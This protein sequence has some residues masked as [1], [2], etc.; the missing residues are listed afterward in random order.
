MTRTL[1]VASR[2][3][4]GILAAPLMATLFQYGQFTTHDVLMSRSALIA[5]AVGLTGII[6]VKI[7]APGYYAR[8]N[9]KTPVKIAV[10]T[11]IIT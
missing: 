3:G 2:V 8:Q 4:T 7:L 6:L 9:V 10:L 1:H 5:Y 11:L